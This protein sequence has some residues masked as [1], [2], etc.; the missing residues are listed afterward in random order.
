MKMEQLYPSALLI[1]TVQAQHITALQETMLLG[2]DLMD[3]KSH[4]LFYTRKEKG[5]REFVVALLVD[6]CTKGMYLTLRAV[7]D[8]TRI[9]R[10]NTKFHKFYK[11]TSSYGGKR[12]DRKQ[13]LYKNVEEAGDTSSSNDILLWGGGLKRQNRE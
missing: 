4:T 11:C 13:A 2:K 12:R 7:D 3:M 9:V 6:T 5:T 1:K 10:I 8:S